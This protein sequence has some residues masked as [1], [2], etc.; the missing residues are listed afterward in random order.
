MPKKDIDPPRRLMGR[1]GTLIHGGDRFRWWIALALIVVTLAAY[2]PVRK[3]GF[4]SLDDDAYVESAP[5]VNRGVR[6]VSLVWA[7]TSV[8]SSNWHP[9]TSISHMVDCSLFGLNPVPMHVENVVWHVFNALLVFYIWQTF[10]GGLWRSAFVAAI[11]ALHPLHVE[12]VAWISERKDL[13]CTFFWLLGMASYLHWVRRR[14]A[15]RYGA[16]LVCLIL[17][18][19]SKPMAVTF[20]LTLL[21]LDGWP[22]RRWPAEK[23]RVLLVEKI[24]LF[25]LV[26][27]HGVVTLLVQHADGAT[28]FGER[29][30][31]AVRAGNAL[32]SY[33][34]YLGKTVWPETLSPLYHLTGGWPVGVVAGAFALLAAVSA[35]AWWRR[36]SHPWFLFGWLWYLGT[37]VPVIGL[38]QVGS[39]SMADRYTYVPLLGIFTIVAWAFAGLVARWPASRPLVM[40]VSLALLAGSFAATRRQ[41]PAWENSIRLYERSIEAGEDNAAIRYLMG[42][43]LKSAGRPLPEVVAQFQRAIQLQ[44]DYVN[45]HTQIIVLAIQHRQ[46]DEA[47]RMAEE[48]LRFDPD[49]DALHVNLGSACQWQG[50]LEEAEIHY[51]EALRL[52][53]ASATARRELINLYIRQDRLADLPDQYRELIR[54]KP[55]DATNL[56][57][58]GVLSANLGQFEQSRRYLERALWIDPENPIAR[59]NLPL[60]DQL[61]GQGLR[62]GRNLSP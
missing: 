43:A 9:L 62:D 59:R 58:A 24:P 33:V 13:L 29:F 61:Q 19:L 23:A 5:M 1:A 41:V 50:R 60:L 17:A 40:G 22:L 28:R 49:N 8:H 57:E 11:F 12:S 37:L 51:R 35:W 42:V 53:P 25:A 21:L 16:M 14:S 46:F 31:L 55:W 15:W 54:H 7:F 38:V 3:C 10:L 4:V 30:S 2:E 48:I 20:P 6:V 36:K 34:R 56:A 18:L 47:R 45:A 52:N 26:L 39:Q 27:A 44:P 32:V